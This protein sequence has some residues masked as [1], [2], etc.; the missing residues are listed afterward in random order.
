LSLQWTNLI[1]GFIDYRS[2][3]NSDGRSSI[4]FHWLARSLKGG[5][6]AANRRRDNIDLTSDGPHATI[7]IDKKRRGRNSQQRLGVSN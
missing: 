6:C 4:S 2:V 7:S 1:G 5:A 3:N